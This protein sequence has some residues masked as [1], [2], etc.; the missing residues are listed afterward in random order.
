MIAPHA[1]GH[2]IDVQVCFWRG[3]H[4]IWPGDQAIRSVIE[5][6]QYAFQSP[7]PAYIGCTAVTGVWNPI[8][9]CSEFQ[10]LVNCSK[11]NLRVMVL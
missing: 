8:L 3:G 9:A 6:E 10:Y 5:F 4:W 1:P 2:L 11:C 7:F